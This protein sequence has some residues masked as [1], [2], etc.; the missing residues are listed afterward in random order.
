MVQQAVDSQGLQR[1][2]HVLRLAENTAAVVWVE[3]RYTNTT[4]TNSP[5]SAGLLLRWVGLG[6]GTGGCL[7]WG[8]TGGGSESAEEAGRGRSSTMRDT[9]L[10]GFATA[11]EEEEDEEEEDEDEEV[12]AAVRNLGGCS[13]CLLDGSS[14]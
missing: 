14:C 2:E 3:E 12:G 7:A 8:G 9:V 4:A 10:G 6:G 1:L 11:T 13:A 5:N